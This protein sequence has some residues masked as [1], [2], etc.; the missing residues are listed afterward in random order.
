LRSAQIEF[1]LEKKGPLAT[2]VL[3]IGVE[4][5][6]FVPNLGLDVL[7]L[8]DEISPSGREDRKGLGDEN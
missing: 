5:G 1:C 7:S 3:H 2:Q 6:Y 4:E 8:L